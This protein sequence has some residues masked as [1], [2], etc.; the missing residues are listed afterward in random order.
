M[1]LPIRK[2]RTAPALQ[3]PPA[4]DSPASADSEPAPR[5]ASAEEAAWNH[6]YYQLHQYHRQHG[7]CELPAHDKAYH[8]LAAWV[9]QQR[10]LQ[11]RG[12]L[13]PERQAALDALGLAWPAEDEA[14]EE[15]SRSP[16][17]EARWRLRYAELVAFQQA[18]GHT[19]VSR[20]A[21]A[22]DTLCNWRHIQRLWRRNGILQP[23]RIALL[24]A[25]GFEWQEPESF[26]RTRGERN[27]H[28]WE[29][30][31]QQL[32]QFKARFGHC[33]V[34]AKWH[35]NPD[36]GK[37]VGRQRTAHGS[38]EL[39]PDRQ[40]RLEALGF[41]WHL[42]RGGHGVEMWERQFA[43]LLAFQA[44]TGHTRTSSATGG[45]RAS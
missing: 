36:L 4:A 26:G 43:D 6:A 45:A 25:I 3:Q 13:P 38:Q 39:R 23:E 44:I 27:E 17:H 11:Q 42:G 12:K 40:A 24:D 9:A 19:R 15:T 34:V 29:Q 28:H 35:E 7:R 37:W 8:K 18:H 20:S 22:S 21:G 2:P 14:E 10:A 30:M 33:R 31:F 41:T 1:F 32:V 16:G 5:L